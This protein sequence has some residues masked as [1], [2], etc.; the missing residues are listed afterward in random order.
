MEKNTFLIY[1]DLVYE[2]HTCNTL[3]DI[4]TLFLPHLKML[5]PYSYAS[6]LLTDPKSTKNEL[7]CMDPI[8]VP[9]SFKEA[10][11]NYIAHQEEDPVAWLMHGTESNLIRESDILEESTRLSSPLYLHCYKNF[12]VYDTIYLTILRELK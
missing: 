8:C 9:E 11:I 6:I 3:E 5:I 1:N 2:M 10:E 12:N 7:F 4:K